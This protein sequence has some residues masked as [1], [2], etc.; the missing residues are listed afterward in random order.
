MKDF[1]ISALIIV[2]FFWFIVGIANR[3][4]RELDHKCVEQFGQGWVGK[5]SRGPEICVND[6]GEGKYVK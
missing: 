4:Q 2:C 5:M 1:F 3:S 6:N